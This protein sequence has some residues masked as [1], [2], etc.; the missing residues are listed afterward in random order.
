MPD[1]PVTTDLSKF[2]FRE[3]KMAAELLTAYTRGGGKPDNLG[4]GVTVAMNTSSG[5]VFLTDEDYN[6]AMMNG[7]K[8]EP[9]L[10]CSNCGEEGFAEDVGE[11]DNQGRCKECSTKEDD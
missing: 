11:L 9:W 8:L 1:D 10:N 3:L 7:D 6:V 2:G 4:D 5:Y